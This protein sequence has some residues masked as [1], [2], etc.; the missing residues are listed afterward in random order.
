VQK[1]VLHER[2]ERVLILTLKGETSLNLGVMDRDFYQA[3]DEYQ[4]DPDLWCV[5]IIG[6]GER[7]FCA[8]GN[9][10]QVARDGFNWTFWDPAPRTFLTGEPFAKPVIA[11]VNGYA[12]GGGMMLALGCD[13]RIASENASFG[14]PEIK[15]GFVPGLGA[16]QRL[17]RAI[18]IGPALEMLLTGD[19]ISAQQAERWGLVNRVVPQA[20]LLETA[21]ALAQRIAANPPRAV[22]ISKELAWRSLDQPLDQGIRLED[23]MT[24]LVRNTDDAR[25]GL[26]A[27]TEKRAPRFTGK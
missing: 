22:S 12:L 17:P 4:A 14:L 5:V 25:E 11:A 18:A 20:D 8:G 21:V 1:V 26:Q 10:K 6:H 15:L 9:V 2:R 23:S 24:Q 19:P 3:L 7:A 16:T 27:F 13:I